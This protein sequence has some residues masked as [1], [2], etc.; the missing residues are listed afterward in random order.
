LPLKD[1]KSLSNN[2]SEV[3]ALELRATKQKTN[4]S[5]CAAEQELL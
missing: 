3:L 5:G 2:R 4:L 1:R